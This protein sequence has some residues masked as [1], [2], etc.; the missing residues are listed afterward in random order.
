M[1]RCSARF[2]FTKHV[3][4][5]QGLGQHVGGT[6]SPTRTKIESTEDVKSILYP[7]MREKE[8]LVTFQSSGHC[9]AIAC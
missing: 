9:S 1:I 8:K 6:D 5:W 3:G 7:R 2:V 4:E